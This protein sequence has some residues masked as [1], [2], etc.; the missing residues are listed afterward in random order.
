M[1]FSALKE[2]RSSFAT[3]LTIK[4]DL[5]DYSGGN[6]G[7][8]GSIGS[9]SWSP[10]YVGVKVSIVNSSN[11]VEDVEI[12]VNENGKAGKFSY[13]NLPKTKQSYDITWVESSERTAYENTNL[14]KSWLNGSNKNINLYSYL[15]TDNYDLLI[16]LIETSGAFN[17]LSTGDYILVEPMVYIGG[18]YGTGFELGRAF[19]K[20]NSC[21][22]GSFCYNYGRRIFGGSSTNTSGGLF[23]TTL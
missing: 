3:C 18:Y 9:G 11:T 23:F 20:I 2:L 7:A 1:H 19:F 21:N 6:T 15:A 10:G 13:E 12:F 5:I 17:T 22:S 14:P 8:S 4:A 16:E